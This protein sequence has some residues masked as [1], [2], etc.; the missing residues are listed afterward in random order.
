[1]SRKY[2][3]RLDRLE[4]LAGFNSGPPCTCA[5]IGALTV[6]KDMLGVSSYGDNGNTP[7]NIMP[8]IPCGA[9]IH[10]YEP[11]Y[12][13]PVPK[14][15]VDMEALMVEM[16]GD[17]VPYPEPNVAIEG[18]EYLAARMKRLEGDEETP[19]PEE[20]MSRPKKIQA[21][22]KAIADRIRKM[23]PLSATK[24]QDKTADW[25]ALPSELED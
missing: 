20:L 13:R 1:M 9:R 23:R 2:N 19:S 22:Q 10:Y 6:V 5:E 3:R 7:V 18:P 12:K 16:F 25:L 21:V 4:D 8:V 24:E 17:D 14:P 11:E 15:D